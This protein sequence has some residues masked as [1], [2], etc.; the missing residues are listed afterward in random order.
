MFQEE[1]MQLIIEH[2][3]KHNRI[4]AEEIV[5]LFDVSRDTARRDLIKLEEQEA[6]I[7]TRGGAILPSPPQEFRSYQERLKYV[8]EEKERLENSLLLLF[9]Q[10]K[11]LFWIPLQLCRPAQR[12]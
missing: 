4:S 1:R 5:T 11:P 10:V 2:L 6:I 8:S 7:R 9:V 12:I 3:R